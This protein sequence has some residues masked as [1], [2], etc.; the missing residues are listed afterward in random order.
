MK[1]R[2]EDELLDPQ[3]R[4]RIIQ[5]IQAGE[6]TSR[7][8]EAFKRYEVL[9]DRVKKYILINLEQEL[10]PQT[11]QD[12]QSRISN[13]NLY[14]KVVSKKARVYKNAPVREAREGTDQAQLDKLIDK[15]QMNVKM[16]KTNR[17]LEAFNNAD[18][19]VR[20]IK[21][22]LT[23]KWYYRV[24]PMGPHQYDVVEDAN[25]PERAMGYI[26]S[27]YEA[28]VLVDDDPQ[29][30]R[31]TGLQP[32]FRDGNNKQ[33]SIADSPGDQ[34]KEFIWWGTKYHFTMD[35]SGQMI[36]GNGVR[37]S[38]IPTQEELTTILNP[39]QHLPVASLARDRDGSFWALG[40]ED[41]I[42]GT[43]LVNTVISDILF[44]AKLHGTGL[45]YFFG[46]GVPSTYKVGPN[47][48]VTL[49]VGEDDPTPQ[50]GFANANPQLQEMKGL[51]EQFVAMLL[52][53]NDL[54]PGAVQGK[55]EGSTMT[56]GVQELI[57]KSE[58]INSVEDDQEIFRV[59]EPE[60]STI[61]AKWHNL[62]FDRDLLRDDFKELGKMPDKV[63]YVMKFGA[64]QHFTTE[65]DKLTVIEK[66]MALGLDDL[67]GAIMIDNPDM[68]EKEAEKKVAE[69]L[70][71]K[72]KRQ[73][74][75]LTNMINEEVGDD[76][77]GDGDEDENAD[78][79]EQDQLQD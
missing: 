16:K 20:P 33:E 61:A 52:T 36:N 77:D 45:F 74:K 68:S 65:M 18:V 38:P 71:R 7:K 50:I 23:G 26:F 21:D 28:Q 35:E 47:Q 5:E 4:Q 64:L 1:I 2:S 79:E 62:Y 59:E 48:G 55:L 73:E 40:G 63:D 15:T 31:G 72:L 51:I 9:K 24:D 19:F 8:A 58:P 70:E 12:M 10:D 13:I 49:D 37:L 75:A 17:Y 27:P 22:S 66:R 43:I 39:I 41:L 76:G 32:N 60:V 44:I 54:E 56:S 25:D 53:T 14:K 6:N 29:D 78:K 57:V 67:V 11:V 3:V 46:K 42:E 30:R 69:L 34:K